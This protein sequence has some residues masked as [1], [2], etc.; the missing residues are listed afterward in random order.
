MS[1]LM[2]FRSLLRQSKIERLTFSRCKSIGGGNRVS[3]DSTLKLFVRRR[4]N[5]V[6]K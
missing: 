6:Y 4:S 1:N 5:G 2:G 3:C